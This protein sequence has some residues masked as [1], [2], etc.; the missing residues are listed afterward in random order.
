[1]KYYSY[2]DKNSIIN[3]SNS[4]LKHFGVTPFHSTIGK[5]DKILENKDK[6]C[7]ILLD[8]N[9]EAIQER[10]L[11]KDDSLRTHQKL[12]VSSTFPPTTVAATNGLLT[13]KYPCETGWIGWTTYIK[14]LDQVVEMF[15]SK[16]YIT[17]K[18]V[19]PKN[20]CYGLYPVKNINELIKEKKP[21]IFAESIYFL[22]DKAR[23]SLTNPEDLFAEASKKLCSFDKGFLY[24]YS[25]EP[26]HSLHTY[27][28]NSQIVKDLCFRLNNHVEKLASE[29]KDTLFIVL[30]DHSHILVNPI[31][32]DDYPEFFECLERC[33]AIEARTAAFKVKNGM[34]NQ[35]VEQYKK[36]FS[37]D[38]SLVD[39]KDA[40]KQHLFGHGKNFDDI[41]DVL[42]D[43]ILI[44]TSDKYF[45]Y[46]H[47]KENHPPFVSTHGGGTKEENI[48]SV[49]IYNE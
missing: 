7:L 35:F 29:N 24:V 33:F 39:A 32:L 25:M 4:I 27:G 34:E 31:Y 5:I 2:D 23:T 19:T 14:R 13:G 48:I 28:S 26:D 9:G 11:N 10:T 37:N 21:N 47:T 40:I 20:I 22:D 44:A 45:I 49:S 46:K 6:V 8:G 36:N 30:A 16:D 18:I 41:K 1:M 3:L 15:T 43:Y 17:K 42:G 12:L 38:F